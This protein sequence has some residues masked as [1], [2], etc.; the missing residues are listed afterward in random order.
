VLDPAG[1]LGY[2]LEPYGFHCWDID[3]RPTP[4][5]APG[6]RFVTAQIVTGPGEYLEDS[7][8]LVI[9]QPAPPV[10][11]LPLTEVMAQQQAVDA[12]LESELGITLASTELSV[13]PGAAAP[14]EVAVANRCMS[15]IRGEAQ[16]ISPFGSWRRIRPW[17]MAFAAEPGGTTNLTFELDV[18]ASARP[19]EQW[20]AIIKLM[21]FGRVRYSLPVQVSV[22]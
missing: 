5:A 16:L 19:G 21:Y 20:W 9:G 6:R 14:L 13:A 11:D 10:L 8:L 15:A 1:P 12:A 7:A 3:V 22:A 18:P 17:T 4:G 2:E